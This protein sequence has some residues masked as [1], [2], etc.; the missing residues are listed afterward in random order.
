MCMDSCTINKITIKYCFPVPRL[1]DM[2]DLMTSASLFSKIN[3]RSGYVKSE[4]SQVMN[5][6]QLLKLKMVFMNGL[7]MPFGPANPPSTFMR[8]MNQMGVMAL[9]I[10]LVPLRLEACP[11]AEADNFIKHMQ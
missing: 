3:L 2:L 8:V 11:S 6:K 7:V 4:L 9:T 1:D 10:D 5:G